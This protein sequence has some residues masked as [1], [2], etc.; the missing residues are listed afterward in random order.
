VVGL[1]SQTAV[2][3]RTQLS[4]EP[5]L[6]G[7]ARVSKGDEQS[8]VAQARALNAAGC[9]RI[10]EEAASGGRWDRPRLQ[11]MVSQLREGDVV[12]VWKLDR[13]SRSLKDLL[14]LMEK[15]EVAGAGFRSLTE[16]IDTTTPAGRM[17]M[18]MVGSFAEFERA[19]IRERTSAGLA[20]ARLEGR[21]GGRRRKLGD[22][23]RREIAESVISGRKSGAEMARLYDVSEPTVSRIVA[24]FR[25]NTAPEAP[26]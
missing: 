19:M 17:M 22:K 15:I 25:Q 1:L 24:E 14:H 2:C 16:A 23:K 20:Q 18:Q 11:E 8:N 26:A 4:G 5:Y 6:I 12:V 21:V 3:E 9:K 10:F 7:Y 13:L